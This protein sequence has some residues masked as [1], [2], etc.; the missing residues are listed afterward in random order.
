MLKIKK[1]DF[2]QYFY[3]EKFIFILAETFAIRDNMVEK[4]W[5]YA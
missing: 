2:L 4:K 1:W 3:K 5:D